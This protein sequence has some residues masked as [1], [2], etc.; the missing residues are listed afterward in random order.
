MAA[1]TGRCIT[2]LCPPSLLSMLLPIYPNRRES[3]YSPQLIIIKESSTVAH[4]C[5]LKAREAEAGGSLT[6]AGDRSRRVTAS[7]KDTVLR[8]NVDR[9]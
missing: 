9:D 8:N 3:S 1:D 7:M 6:L 5:N 2:G 4:T